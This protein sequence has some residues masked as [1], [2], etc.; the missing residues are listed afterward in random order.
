[1]SLTSVSGTER[2]VTVA[3]AG[4]PNAGK[5]SIFNG[6]TGARRKVANYPGVTVEKREGT[7]MVDGNRYEVLDLPGTYSLSAF[8]PEE[9]IAE[10][11]LLEGGPDVTVVVC[12]STALNRGLVLLAQV[13]QTGANPVLCL[14]MTDEAREAGLELDVDAMRSLLGIPV[15]QT[16]GRTGEGLD[17]LQRVVN[18]AAANPINKSRLVL[19]ERMDLAIEAVAGALDGNW[20]RSASLDWTASRLLQGHDETVRT[21]ESLGD[22]G[23]AA[24]EEARQGRERIEAETGTDIQVFVSERLFGFVDGLLKEVTLKSSRS[25]ARA[26]S[27]RVDSILA[28]RILGLPFFLAVMY[29]V[30]WLTFTVGET[31]MGWI[32]GVFEV[33]GSLVSSLWPA[34]SQSA[35][36]S[37][38][39]DGII[40]GV[41][42][43]IVFLPNIIL[44]FLGLAVLE[45]TGYMARAAFLVDRFM[46]RFGLHGKSFIPMMT[47]FGCSI[48][49]IMGTR[50]LE[51][52]RDRLTTMLV[53]PLISCGARLPIWMLLI[54]AFFAPAWRAPM[55]WFIYVFGV[56]LALV[57][58]L[59]LRSTLLKGS[60]APFVMELPP[61]RL[62][63]L[64]GLVA[65]M[66]ERSW[67]YVRKAGTIILGISIVLW[68]LTSYPKPD[69][70]TIQVEESESARAAEDL[71][72]SFAGRIGTAIEPLIAPL[73]FDWKLGTA[74]IGAFAAKEVFVSQMGIVHS[75]GETDEESVPLRESLSSEYSPLVGLSLML[76]LL[77]SAPCMAT[78]AV[79]RRESGRWKWALLQLGGLTAVAWLVSLAVY[80]VGSLV[81]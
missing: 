19:G 23:R 21:V 67:L 65:K 79:T 28:H 35:L 59:L 33:S 8:S 76:F 61:Y 6:L 2:V 70:Y 31:P 54:P 20:D 45:D 46:H 3:L 26:V 52:E 17:E 68:V 30:F 58:A 50:V 1:M 15:V 80:Q 74:M 12:D 78:I 44:L 51:N 47:G 9:R 11:E 34:G 27:D 40:A 14:N 57:L 60:D 38:L 16:V 32:E 41:G 62:P 29:G 5:T 39:V 7:Y 77:V 48:P 24:V 73:G 72:F 37:L 66:F 43:V 18:E 75:L 13:M 81:T 71:R 42:G 55:L 36:R 10:H 63:T 53:L 69:V 64:R 56:L 4:N 22:A 49:G 25:D